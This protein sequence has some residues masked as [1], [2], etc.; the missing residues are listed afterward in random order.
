MI[1]VKG[2]PLTASFQWAR[3]SNSARSL[4]SQ[5]ATEVL[6]DAE[7]AKRGFVVKAA[8]AHALSQA[9]SQVVPKH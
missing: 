9:K 2:V 5:G 7:A 1:G 4:R 8:K 3:W 6:T